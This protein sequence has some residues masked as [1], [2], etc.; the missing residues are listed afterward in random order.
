LFLFCELVICKYRYYLQPTKLFNNFFS[1]FFRIVVFT[2][3]S[4]ANFFSCLRFYPYFVTKFVRFY[5]Y[6]IHNRSVVYTFW[7][8]VYIGKALKVGEK[9]LMSLISC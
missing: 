4:D 3:V 5:P 2:R 9:H 6:F 7:R 8:F 1:H